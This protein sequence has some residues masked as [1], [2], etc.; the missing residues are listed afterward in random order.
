MT[1]QEYTAN[2]SSE[3]EASEFS[4]STGARELCREGSL[5]F[6]SHSINS[7]KH[8]NSKHRFHLLLKVDFYNEIKVIMKLK[9]YW[10]DRVIILE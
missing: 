2:L 1:A 10:L 4:F 7:S 3:R 6:V 5:S 9:S 8:L